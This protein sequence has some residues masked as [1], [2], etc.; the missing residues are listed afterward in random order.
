[1]SKMVRFKLSPPPE[2]YDWIQANYKTLGYE[3]PSKM[4]AYLVIEAYM[5]DQAL[6]QR[7]KQE[8]DV[9]LTLGEEY[10]RLIEEIGRMNGEFD[11]QFQA[12]RSLI[13][14]D[15]HP[16]NTEEDLKKLM[17]IITQKVGEKGGFVRVEGEDVAISREDVQA[18]ER[19]GML[20]LKGKRMSQILEEQGWKPSDCMHTH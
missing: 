18:Y 14:E 13:A 19:L 10:C 8:S 7:A 2:V 11:A 9:P 1:M 6:K 12:I 16:V 15:A 3:S 17:S 20:H 5:K 4:V